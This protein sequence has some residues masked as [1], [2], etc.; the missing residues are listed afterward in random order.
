[1][2]LESDG[3]ISVYEINGGKV[4]ASLEGLEV[5]SE[6]VN[7]IGYLDNLSKSGFPSAKQYSDKLREILKP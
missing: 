5:Y 4:I 7:V 1:M 3:C 6:I 2:G